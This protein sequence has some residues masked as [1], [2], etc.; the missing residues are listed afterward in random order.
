[1]LSAG[2][3]AAVVAALILKYALRFALTLDKILK[4]FEQPLLLIFELDAE[5]RVLLV[6]A[7]F[8]LLNPEYELVGVYSKWV[9]FY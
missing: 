2:A 6:V 4:S 7:S 8:G 9:F 1:L 3:V 5:N